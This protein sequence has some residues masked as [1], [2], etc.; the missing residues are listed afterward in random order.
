MEIHANAPSRRVPVCPNVNIV[1]T[2]SSVC[3]YENLKEVGW[4]EGPDRA[5]RF[6]QLQ[7]FPFYEVI[8]DHF[9]TL[10]SEENP[11]FR[12][13]SSQTCLVAGGKKPSRNY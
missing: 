13:G 7:L 2:Y 1:R 12:P 11:D 5:Y 3:D 6:R 4:V 10:Y 9:E 8:E